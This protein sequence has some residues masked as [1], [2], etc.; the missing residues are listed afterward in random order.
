MNKEK[1]TQLLHSIRKQSTFD[2]IHKLIVWNMS[3]YQTV[4]INEPTKGLHV[5]SQNIEVDHHMMP[6]NLVDLAPQSLG[7]SFGSTISWSKF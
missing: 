6:P 4:N 7:Q 2:D 5:V 3:R 1:L